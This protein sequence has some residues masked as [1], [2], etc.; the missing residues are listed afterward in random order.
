MT[1]LPK[2][3]YKF[4]AIPIK[5]PIFFTEIEQITLKFVWKQKRPQI[6]KD[7]LKKLEVSC[8]LIS[9]NTTSYSHQ[10]NMILAQKQTHRSMEQK[11]KHRRSFK[12]AEE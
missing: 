5:I 6:S 12:M 7:I 10:N 2:A 9:N 1:I 3:V 11:R 4:N 8:S